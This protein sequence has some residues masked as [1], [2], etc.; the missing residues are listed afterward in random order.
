MDRMAAHPSSFV[1]IPHIAP[2]P[3]G[4]SAPSGH[5]LSLLQPNS[6]VRKALGGPNSEL[7]CNFSTPSWGDAPRVS[8]GTSQ[9]KTASKAGVGVGWLCG[10][11]RPPG[12]EDHWETSRGRTGLFGQGALV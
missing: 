11:I 2:A 8:A 10:S 12:G 1:R 3:P 4:A 5:K 7:R 9:W 6:L